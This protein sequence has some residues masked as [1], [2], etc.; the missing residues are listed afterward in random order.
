M[1]DIMLTARHYNSSSNS[2]PLTNPSLQDI[3][4]TWS[5]ISDIPERTLSIAYNSNNLFIGVGINGS[6]LK[7]DDG[8]LWTEVES[9]TNQL[10]NKVIWADDRF[11][12]V[13][14]SDIL[15]SIDGDNWIKC[16]GDNNFILNDIAWN[17]S[18]FVAVGASSII[19]S[20]NGMEWFTPI[21]PSGGNLNTVI[22]D[23][24]QFIVHGPFCIYRSKDAV[25]WQSFN[26]PYFEFSNIAFNNTS[27][28]M[29]GAGLN[30]S[31]NGVTWYPPR[32]IP[33]LFFTNIIWDG[34]QYITFAPNNIS[35]VSPDGV[36]WKAYSSQH[37]DYC[38][39]YT[40]LLG[41]FRNK[42]FLRGLNNN[43]VIGELAESVDYPNG[44]ISH[45]P[46]CN[47][48]HSQHKLPVFYLI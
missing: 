28:V 3:G 23:G 35:Y 45:N 41:Y 5:E 16:N 1:L 33:Q 38:E 6:I 2:Y 13:G 12:A 26:G 20:R 11:I 24:K 4:I 22:W 48:E 21:Q 14:E 27:Y 18:M 44:P 40:E 39:Q 37:S 36:L 31:T 46:L 15:M 19:A 7:S 29:I 8:I 30:Y 17:G 47:Q 34:K 25:S 10:L 42:C 43:I 32:S 9:P